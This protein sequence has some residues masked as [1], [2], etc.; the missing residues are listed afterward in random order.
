MM[1]MAICIR[2]GSEKLGGFGPCPNC[3]FRPTDVKDLAQSLFLTDHYHTR[4]ALIEAAQKIK[5]GTFAVDPEVLAPFIAEI[6]RDQ[7]W[8]ERIQHPER[9]KPGLMWRVLPW[10]VAL[11][12]VAVIV[13]QFWMFF[14]KK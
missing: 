14:H 8:L 10:I 3:G 11:G 13:F 2:C 9:F 1:T 12:L 5:G 4:E 6:K 7:N